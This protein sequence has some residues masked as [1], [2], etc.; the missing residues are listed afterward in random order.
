MFFF[1]G[2]RPFLCNQCGKA[3]TRRETLMEHGYVHK[4][5]SDKPHKCTECGKGFFK[6]YDLQ[7][8]FTGIHSGL[9]PF[10]CHLCGKF[11]T[12][13]TLFFR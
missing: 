4:P 7:R 10:Q 13:I 6:L 1:L 2:E 12:G 3:F 11:I 5:D 9:K 8:H